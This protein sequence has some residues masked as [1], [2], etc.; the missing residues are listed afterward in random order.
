MEKEKNVRIPQQKRS[1][2]KKERIL[3]AAY[4]LF[5]ENGFAKTTTSEIAASAG[6]SVGSLYSYFTDKHHIFFEIML[7]YDERF[8]ALHEEFFTRIEELRESPAV[9]L[10]AYLEALIQIHQD[11]ADFQREMKILYYS[12]PDI[13]HRLD[14]GAENVRQVIEQYLQLAQKPLRITDLEATTQLLSLMVSAVVDY[15]FLSSR[16]VEKERILNEF[17]TAMNRYIFDLT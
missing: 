8:N 5:C 10:R 7:R 15:L 12:D 13:A 9:W 11:T 14:A 6:V 17:I 2:E 1:V 4:R 3:D 16:P